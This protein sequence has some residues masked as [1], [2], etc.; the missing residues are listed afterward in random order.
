MNIAALIDE[1]GRVIGEVFNP[2]KEVS[3]IK[4]TSG[5]TATGE[6][7]NVKTYKISRSKK[8]LESD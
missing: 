7:V 4:V 6:L 2:P 3:E 1:K 5:F 8:D